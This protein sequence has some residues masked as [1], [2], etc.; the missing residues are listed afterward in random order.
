MERRHKWGGVKTTSKAA[1]SHPVFQDS[2]PEAS[3][4]LSNRRALVGSGCTVNS[5]FDGVQ[6]VSGV[7]NLSGLCNDDLDDYA[8]FPGLANVT[9]G[10]SPVVSVKD[11]KNHY[12]AGTEAGFAICAKSDS[13]LLGLDLVKFYKIQFLCDG[14]TVGDLQ[15]VSVGQDITGLGLSL[16]Q[17]PGSDLVTKSF[18]AKAPAEF[19]EVKLYQFGVDA[20]VLTSVKHRARRKRAEPLQHTAPKSGRRRDVTLER[21]VS[22]TDRQPGDTQDATEHRRAKGTYFDEMVLYN[23]GV[24]AADLS[25]L[26]ILRPQRHTP[27]QCRH[28]QRRVY[29]ERKEIRKKI[30]T[31]EKYDEKEIYKAYMH[32]D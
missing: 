8:T 7:S 2:D 4:Y 22:R 13:K 1:K 18:S 21:R 25:Q 3:N 27:E 31:E 24:L 6:L 30:T 19:D 29:H 11:R 20:A 14:K 10:G 26:N 15:S 5:L 28:A 9:V 16:I 32:C 17:V 12:A 23:F